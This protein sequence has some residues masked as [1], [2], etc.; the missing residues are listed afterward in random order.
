M[1]EGD[2]VQLL[3][4]L[5]KEKCIVIRERTPVEIILYSVFLYL[6]RLSLRDVAMAICIFIKRSRTA[7]WKW[8]QKFES[9][10]ENK[11]ADKMPDI[12]VIDETSLQIGDMNFWFWF[13]IDPENRK[14]VFF[15]IS[16]SR[17]NIACR[18]LIYKMWKMYGKLPS[19]AITDGGPWYLILKR[20]G[21]DH[22]IVSGGIRNYV[23]RVIETIKDRTRV[24]DNYFPSKRWKIRHVYLWF[25]I[26]IFYYNWIRSHQSLSNNSPVFYQ[27][28]I[29]IDN[30][31]ER[32]ILALQEVLQCLS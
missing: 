5:L 16:R 11:I 8:L 17:T 31:Y 3:K 7:I 23:E 21:I 20:Y 25:S 26:Y 4:Y 1:R 22:E 18:N 10:L 28:N 2:G 12:V 24:F 15:M 27:R 13:V 30:E 9:I 29:K 19:V 6:C 32:F 14:V